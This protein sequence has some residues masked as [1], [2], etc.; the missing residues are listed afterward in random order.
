[1]PNNNKTILAEMAPHIH[2]A[3]IVAYCVLQASPKIIGPL[4]AIQPF[5]TQSNYT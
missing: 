4:Q 2:T 1:V 3:V 5:I